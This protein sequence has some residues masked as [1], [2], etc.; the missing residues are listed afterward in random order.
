MAAAVR[1]G[2]VR[3]DGVGLVWAGAARPRPG[4]RSWS[5][6]APTASRTTCCRTGFNARTAVHE[7][8]GAAWWVHDAASV[9][10]LGRPAP[11][12]ARARRHARCRSR[13]SPTGR[14]ACGTPTAT[15]APDGRIVCVRERHARRGPPR[16]CATRSS[17]A[18]AVPDRAGGAASAGPT[19][20][21]RRGCARTAATLAWLQWDHPECRGTRPA[22]GPRPGDRRGV[23]GRRRAGESV[24]EPRWRPTARC[25]SSPTAPTGGTSTGQPGRDIEPWSGRGR[26]RRAAWTLGSA[27]YAVLPDGRGRVRALAPDGFDRLARRD[28]DG[29][30]TDLDLPFSQFGAVIAAGDGTVV[31]VAG[32][33]DRRA[34]AST[35]VDVDGRAAGQR[36]CARRATSASP[37][38]LSDAGA[39]QLPR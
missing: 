12:P 3:V 18:R 11:L 39:R 32:Q 2:E 10:R 20:S 30:L 24:S 25:G 1:L 13:P 23:R 27:R 4:A 7:L 5:A 31:V 6:V 37:A 38:D 36:R 19:S 29:T 9:R 16:T 33:P 15:P 22:G 21:R 34:R 26:D 35:A 8:G 17:A 14:A 28:A